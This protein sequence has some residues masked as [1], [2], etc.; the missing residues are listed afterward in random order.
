MRKTATCI[1]TV[2]MCI[3]M[4]TG[5][6]AGKTLEQRISQRDRERFCEEMKKTDENSDFYDHWELDVKE[7]H[8]YFKAFIGVHLDHTERLA[9]KSYIMDMDEDVRINQIKDKIEKAYRIRPSMISIEFYTSDDILLGK[10]E[11]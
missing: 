9:I 10:I 2:F 4:F 6:F 8:L 7:N 3:F 1:L 5:C 11:H